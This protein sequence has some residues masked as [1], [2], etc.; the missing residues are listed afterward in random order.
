[1]TPPSGQPGH[2][3]VNEAARL[4]DVAKG[5]A[6]KVLASGATVRRAGDE[7]DRWP[8]VGAVALRGRTSPTPISAPLV[9]APA[10]PDGVAWR[11][12]LPGRADP[13]FPIR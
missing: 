12:T 10:R 11:P 1:M 7:A 6:V 13:A 8:D 2:S 3:A 5:R 9:D 4:T